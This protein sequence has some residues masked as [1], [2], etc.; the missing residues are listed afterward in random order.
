MMALESVGSP[1][2]WAAFTLLIVALLALDLGFFHRK[3]HEVSV[4]EA[5]AWTAGWVG[6]ALMFNVFVWQRFGAARGLEFLTGYLIE[7]ALS[8]DNIFV[9]L[10][11]FSYFAVP[12]AFQHRVLFWGIVGA[13]IFRATFILLGAALL[14][15]FHWIVYVFGVLLVATGIKLLV[16]RG[17]EVHPERNPI[18]RVFKRFVPS[19]DDYRGARFVVKENGKRL[20][21]PLLLVVVVVESTDVVFAVDSIPAIFAVTTDPFIVYTSNIFAILGLRALYFVLAG[22]MDRF[23]YL[24]IALAT[25]LCFVGVKM[26]IVDLYKV[27]IGLSL[28]VVA[29]VLFVSVIASLLRPRTRGPSRVSGDVPVLSVP[30]LSALPPGTNRD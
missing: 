28:G 30:T 2:L 7:K 17:T 21:T 22:V 27:P 18:Y 25:V 11:I 29:L 23:H 8:V 10:V 16:E 20:A 1:V 26:L 15:R 13:L 3:A 12:R 5:L 4:K 9:F 6:L 24:R 19:V 14:Q